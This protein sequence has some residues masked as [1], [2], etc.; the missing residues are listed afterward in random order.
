VTWGVHALLPAGL[1]SY[2]MS[3]KYE[4]A[5]ITDMEGHHR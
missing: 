2:G 3:K 1:L 5:Q 4:S